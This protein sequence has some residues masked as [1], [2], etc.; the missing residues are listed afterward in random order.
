[1]GLPLAAQAHT[2]EIRGKTGLVR[3]AGKKRWEQE[4]DSDGIS[5]GIRVLDADE[6]EQ[7]LEIRQH[8]RPISRDT[9]PLGNHQGDLSVLHDNSSS[10]P[11]C[12]IE[13]TPQQINRYN[14]APP[15]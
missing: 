13:E 5:G 2:V 12:R 8:P 15:R 10:P 9:T 3:W 11:G 14:E 6:I 7:A 1:V 4:R